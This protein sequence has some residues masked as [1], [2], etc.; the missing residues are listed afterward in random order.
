MTGS[1]SRQ[2]Q[3]CTPANWRMQSQLV[4]QTLADQWAIMLC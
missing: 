2:C 4:Q 3:I 1:L